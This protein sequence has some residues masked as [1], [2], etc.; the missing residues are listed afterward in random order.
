MYIYMCV[1]INVY[2]NVYALACDRDVL[3]AELAEMEAKVTACEHG[4]TGIVRQVWRDEK[5]WSKILMLKKKET[6]MSKFHNEIAPRI[7]AAVRARSTDAKDLVN[8]KNSDGGGCVYNVSDDRRVSEANKM[9][10]EEAKN[11]G[12]SNEVVIFAGKA[13]IEMMVE[14]PMNMAWQAVLD[15]FGF[16]KAKDAVAANIIKCFPDSE[17]KWSIIQL[18]KEASMEHGGAVK[19]VLAAGCTNY[20]TLSAKIFVGDE[21]RATIIRRKIKTAKNLL[22]VTET[23]CATPDNM[24]TR[25]AGKGI[26]KD[27]RHKGKGKGQGAGKSKASGGGNSDG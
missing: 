16:T 26:G 10:W 3:A 6:N 12:F 1:Y 8:G 17:G 9:C 13:G 18:K 7:Y 2:I 5:Q 4:L 21:D 20:D 27:G 25:A 24:K 11:T 22:F 15:E 23:I 14:E 19:R